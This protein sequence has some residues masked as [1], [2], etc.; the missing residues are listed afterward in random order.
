[1]SL[2]YQAFAGSSS[3]ALEAGKA[4]LIRSPRTSS[5]AAVGKASREESKLSRSCWMRKGRRRRRQPRRRLNVVGPS[6]NPLLPPFLLSSQLLLRLTH[7]SIT[8]AHHPTTLLFPQFQTFPLPQP[9][10]QPPPSSSLNG[11]PTTKPL[12]LLV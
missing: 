4:M 5:L 10:L 11:N 12:K 9:P 6:Q 3:S 2:F 1:M 7:L 8:L